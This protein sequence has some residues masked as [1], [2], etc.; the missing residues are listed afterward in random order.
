MKP[1]ANWPTIILIW[2]FGIMAGASLGKVIPVIGA[3]IGAMGVT[4][5]QAAW[6]ISLVTLVSVLIAPFGGWLIEQIGDRQVVLAGAIAG[7]LGNFGAVGSHSF[8]PLIA[9]RI[10]ESVGFTGLVLGGTAMMIRVTS[11]PRR[12]NAM[13]LWATGVPV[14]LGVSEGLASLWTHGEWQAPFIIHGIFLVAAAVAV[15][16]LPAWQAADSTAPK[17]GILAIYHYAATLRLGFALTCLV[18]C[19]FGA[20]TIFPTYLLAAHGQAVAIAGTIGGVA[21]L[22]TIFGSNG[23]GIL[24]NRDWTPVTI[25]IWAI[26][27]GAL[28]CAGTFFPGGGIVS[29]SIALCLC[30][31][32][33][34]LGIGLGFAIIA[35]LTPGHAFHPAA[36]SLCNQLV[37]L[38]FVLGAPL[39]F[40]ALKM[41]ISAGPMVLAAIMGVMGLLLLPMASLRL[42]KH[43]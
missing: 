6:M 27:L 39:A 19:Q 4:P 36:G 29:S 40:A 30:N 33:A 38:G 7:I 31:F 23:S 15:K 13:A 24:L 5:D 22:C 14:G 8:A 1:S 35:D 42:A 18:V 43:Q 28:G 16:F 32:G 9:A 3:I 17:P 10:V 12:N 26:C 20:D 37:N 41:Q 25:A 2:F 34:G 21:S 11:G